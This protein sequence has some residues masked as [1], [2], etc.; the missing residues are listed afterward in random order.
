MNPDSGW[1]RERE[2]ANKQKP[3]QLKGS[4]SS[5]HNVIITNVY[6]LFKANLSVV[7]SIDRVE[8]CLCEVGISEAEIVK[9]STMLFVTEK[10]AI[11]DI[12]MSKDAEL[13]IADVLPKCQVISV[14]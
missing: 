9:E 12:R 5:K 3:K 6:E 10:V 11:I 2:E 14:S 4:S 8:S 7:V 13:H 1:L